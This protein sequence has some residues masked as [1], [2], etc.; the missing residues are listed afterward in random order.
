MAPKDGNETKKKEFG[1]GLRAQLQRRRDQPE[2]PTPAE[3][4]PNVELRLELT[5]RPGDGEPLSVV[6]SGASEDLRRQLDAAFAIAR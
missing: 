3:N 5:A 4:Q 1:T 2:A 6:S